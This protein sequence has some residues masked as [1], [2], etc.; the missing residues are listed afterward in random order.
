M[1]SHLLAVVFGTFDIS[2]DKLSDGELWLAQFFRGLSDGATYASLALALVLIYR[3]TGFINFAQGSLALLGVYLAY[4]FS[5]E[6]G[7]PVALAVVFAMAAS[8]LVAAFIERIFIRPFPPNHVL[9]LVIVT[10]GLLLIIDSAVGIVWQFRTRSLPSM[11]PDGAPIQ[12]GIA[13][14]TWRTIG[15]LGTVTVVVCLLYLLLART[16]VGLAFRA[17]S[18]NLESAQLVGIRVGPTLGF[19]WALAAAIGTLG[20]SLV[21]PDLLLEPSVMLRV[22]IFSLAAAALGGLDSMAGAVLGGL[23]VGLARNLL[24]TFLDL[25][26]LALA[27]AV[28]V[29]LVVLLV[30]PT[31]LLGST[32]VERV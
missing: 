6:Q 3:S 14:L 17:V 22:L 7:L 4:V 13:Q 21:V 12:W 15:N 19:G 20:G 16:K 1:S 10:L 30:R 28:A 24:V 26:D 2:L 23:V 27:T 29:I 5:V 9:P 8:A 32:T 11:F 25:S 18:S 31:G